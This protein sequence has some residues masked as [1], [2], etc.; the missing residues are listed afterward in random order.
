MSSVANLA[1]KLADQQLQKKEEGMR[2][3]R[4]SRSCSRSSKTEARAAV[5]RWWWLA[6]SNQTVRDSSRRSRRAGA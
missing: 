3:A 6:E 5:A 4:K 2:S 1:K